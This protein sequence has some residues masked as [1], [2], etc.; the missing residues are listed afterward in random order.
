VSKEAPHIPSRPLTY[1][2]KIPISK[3]GVFWEKL[4]LGEVYATKCRKCGKLYYPP[5]VD[6][7]RC[8]TSEAEW[9]KLSGEGRL[10]SYTW[11]YYQPQGFTQYQKP[12][13]IAVAEVDGGVKVMGW[14]EGVK[15]EEVKIG[16]RVAVSAKT[17]PDGYL[18]IVFS[19]KGDEYG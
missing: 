15:P 18:V 14:L 7:P 9:V 2:H 3:T 12:Y 4:K 1:A 10:F 11:V 17:L 5:Q 13:A 19:P 16:M 6:C 8:L